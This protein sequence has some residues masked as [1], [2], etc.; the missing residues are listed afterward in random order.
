[1][2]VCATY[3][4]RLYHESPQMAGHVLVRML[5]GFEHGKDDHLLSELV[6]LFAGPYY[7]GFFHFPL[8]FLGGGYS[9]GLKVGR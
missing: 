3:S 5:L 9:K 2:L 7:S 1:M 4:K 6:E 8:A